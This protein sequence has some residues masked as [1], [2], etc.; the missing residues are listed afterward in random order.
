M[1]GG[2]G[3]NANGSEGGRW[4]VGVSLTFFSSVNISRGVIGSW[5][6]GFWTFLWCSLQILLRGNEKRLSGRSLSVLW[7]PSYDLTAQFLVAA[8]PGFCQQSHHL[9]HAGGQTVNLLPSRDFIEELGGYK[10]GDRMSSHQVNQQCHF[11]SITV[12]WRTSLK[13]PPLA[14]TWAMNS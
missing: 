12:R 14:W 11:A 1:M 8:K 5:V 4:R 6:W 7:P 9:P 3:G 10:W 2:W 13:C